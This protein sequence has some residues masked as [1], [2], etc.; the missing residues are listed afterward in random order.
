MDYSSLPND[1]DNPGG[2]SPW[3]SSPQPTSRPSF[4]A[5]EADSIPSS[6]LAKHTPYTAD[7]PPGTEG[8]SSD[9]E[10]LVERNTDENPQ[11]STTR[12]RLNGGTQGSSS[13]SQ[14]PPLM[15]QPPQSQPQQHARQPQSQQQRAGPN[16][17]HGGAN[18]N[19]P[20]QNLPQ[21]KLQAKITGL[22][23]TGR[24]DPVLRFDVHVSFIW[25]IALHQNTTDVFYRP[26]FPNS[27]QPS[28]GMFD[29]HI[30][31]SPNLPTT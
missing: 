26:I 12:R 15:Q 21:Y 14:G 17:Y 6:P 5:S 22:E 10:T 19:N 7:S 1:P 20:K 24:K 30:L 13:H 3:Q 4:N 31:N 27:V 18:R 8:G 23:R 28:F 29:E 11:P 9:Q 16:R 25:P 2:S